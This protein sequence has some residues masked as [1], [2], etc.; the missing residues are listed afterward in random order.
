VKSYQVRKERR[1]NNKMNGK[2]QQINNNISLQKVI[3]PADY[4]GVFGSMGSVNYRIE[5]TTLII[6]DGVALLGGVFHPIGEQKIQIKGATRYLCIQQ[7]K[8]ELGQI[9]VVVSKTW[10][11]DSDTHYIAT[12]LIIK[13]DTTQKAITR[14]D[15]IGGN[16]PEVYNLID[17]TLR[18]NNNKLKNID[19]LVHN[20]EQRV[21][22]LAANI[23]DTI[24]KK[25]E[26]TNNV[27]EKS[28]RQLYD[29][30]SNK[31]QSVDTQV[32]N[33]QT[34]LQ[35]VSTKVQNVDTQVKNI[36]TQ[37]KYNQTRLQTV[38]TKVQNIAL[39]KHAI[40]VEFYVWTGSILL[41]QSKINI[42][43]N[44]YSAKSTPFIDN[45]NSAAKK[46]FI[47]QVCNAFHDDKT[48]GS[49]KVMSATGDCIV[50]DRGSRRVG[51]I[52]GVGFKPG[53]KMLICFSDPTDINRSVWC[54]EDGKNGV[55]ISAT[56]HYD[57]TI[58]RVL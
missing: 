45:P 44:I 47:E 36:D 28:I 22:V 31:V 40:R 42:A 34:K 51:T 26:A 13:Q 14:V 57:E 32:K 18:N 9:D 3:L 11:T 49:V 25:V 54:S 52:W 10:E 19:V 41:H 38:S 17:K 1:I 48:I 39:Y 43:F 15:K 7:D 35:T 46:G 16:V 2:K 56:V 24:D 55:A 50:T 8:L 33:N 27:L 30:L 23:G 29:G 6:E 21:E 37:V 5:R 4:E 12:V 20:I 53:K 58:V